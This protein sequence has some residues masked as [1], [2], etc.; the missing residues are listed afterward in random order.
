MARP[1]A[2]HLPEAGLVE[3][4]VHGVGG[5]SPEAVL[6]V[7]AATRLADDLIPDI[8]GDESAGFFQP[9]GPAS[10]VAD[11][12]RRLEAYSWG[13][14]TS[15]S[16]ARALWLILAPF[17]MVNLA[18]WMIEHDGQPTQ[19]TRTASRFDVVNRAIA[20]LVALSL[21]I[22]TFFL[23]T[24]VALD[25]FA[26]QCGSQGRWCGQWWLRPLSFTDGLLGHNLVVGVV[27][28]IGLLGVIG[29]ITRRSQTFLHG[30]PS[31]TG[32]SGFTD[33]AFVRN[34][35]HPEF[36][37]QAGVGHRLGIVHV[38]AGFATIGLTLVGVVQTTSDGRLFGLPTIMLV[39]L[40]LTA[41][42]VGTL[43]FPVL[44]RWALLGAAISSVAAA[45]ALTW[46]VTGA[47]ELSKGPTADLD[48][49]LFSAQIAVIALFV[50]A[51]WVARRAR[52][53][54]ERG[55]VARWLLPPA[56]MVGAVGLIAA[57]GNGFTIAVAALL[58]NAGPRSGDGMASGAVGTI[59]YGQSAGLVASIF[60]LALAAMAIVT[61]GFYLRDRASVAAISSIV[62]EYDPAITPALA[63]RIRRGRALARLPD[64]APEI[65]GAG[66]IT[67]V[68]ILGVLLVRSGGRLEDPV[69]ADTLRPIH[70][71]SSAI[72]LALPV[73]GAFLIFQA[74]RKPGWR[75]VVG[76]IWDV[77][78][79]W[80]R[81]FHPFA[82]PSYGERAI[83]DLERR[84]TQ[85]GASGERIVVSA[86]SQ[87]SLL[88]ASS[89]AVAPTAGTALVT[90]GSPLHRLYARFF[91]EYLGGGFSSR[92]RDRLEGR[93]INLYRLSDY[94][95]GPVPD[96]GDDRV[97]AD[98]LSPL[99]DETLRTHL[100]YDREEPH[101]Q[102][103]RDLFD[104]LR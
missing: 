75:R 46:P 87:G 67:L 102:S 39:L 16:A 50:L 65:L 58:G 9:D 72:L 89:L 88:A 31:A 14:L 20:R 101:A 5:S 64:R 90:H 30:K 73:V 71:F 66:V 91:P 36:W 19:P 32:M 59:V 77:T 97:L 96:C 84:L 68:G 37:Q 70:G 12:D 74:Y 6:G 43:R 17:A 10:R 11:P 41:G 98:P 83:P 57:F 7:E 2:R 26:L 76:I 25:Q 56:L 48:Q 78:T 28:P 61:I 53:V 42:L 54:P 21:T 85:I 62:G 47:W 79:F 92:L 55:S 86:H 103:I 15:R 1:A 23:A 33:P 34:L 35:T 38:A 69:F 49:W 13:G 60:V 63:T 22:E 99:D 8:P 100:A 93:W 29:L 4:R 40:A 24:R 52:P 104:R 80:P 81:W 44:V 18:G 45:M 3:L 95:G 51:T 94:I 82:P 27:F